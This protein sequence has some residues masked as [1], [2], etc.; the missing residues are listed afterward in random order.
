MTELSARY[1]RAESLLP[2]NLRKLVDAPRVT[3][4]W[5]RDTETFWYR[6]MTSAG[7]EFVLVDAEARTTRPA[8][9]HARLAVAL[10]G[11]LEQ[12]VEASALPFF[13]LD[14]R[15]GALRVTV[16]E[17]LVEVSLDSYLAEVVG[18]APGGETFSPDGRWAVGFDGEHDLALR[19]VATDEV[20]VLTGDGEEGYSYAQSPDAS[21][22]RVMQENLGFRTPPHV[23]WSQDS[24]RFVTFRL[25]QRDLELMH[26]VRS[27]PADGGRP[28][29]YSYRYAMVGDEHDGLAEFLVFD[30]A[31]G[32]A[33]AAGCG[34]L[35]NPY[36]SPIALGR[37]W[38]SDDGTTVRF[39]ASERGDRVARLYELD[40]ASGAT[41]VLVEERSESNVLYGPHFQDRNV[42]VLDSGEV[43]WWS[44]RS[45][46][47]HLYRVGADGAATALTSGEWLV[48]RL[49]AVDEESRRVV[50][51][52]AGRDPDADPY[53][54]ELCA[55]SLDG[56][57]VETLAAD[58]LDHETLPSRS[59][60]YFVDVMSAVDTPAVSVLRDL[61]GAVVLE[62]ER[63]DAS[64]LYASGWQAPE[65]V[66]VKAS[67]GV[68]DI[69]CAIYKPFDFDPAR[70]YPVLDEIY[71]GP[72]IS[73]A[74]IRF[75]L[76]GG[77]MVAERS[78]TIFAALGFAVVTVDGRGTAL[79]GKAFQ[80]DAR[81]GNDGGYIADHVAAI[82][83]LAETRP[84]LDLDRVGIYGHSGGGYA[85]TRALL[86]EP[87]FYKVAV[88]SAGDHD[89][90]TYHAWWGEKY[91][92]L[93]D[94][95]DYASHANVSRVENLKGKLL[96]AH[97]EMDDNVTPHL[98]LRLVN[99]LIEANK[100]FDLLI[101]PNAD[102]FM[103][104]NAAYWIRRR[105]D[106]FVRHLLGE[107][108]PEYR[109]ADIPF[110]PEVLASMGG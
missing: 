4:S 23:V 15:D 67:D 6:R 51:T 80:D 97:G 96:L 101:V 109:I 71:S 107:T 62:L 11:V 76:S 68:T 72:Q 53:V 58:G 24:T 92:G 52:A 102:H 66:K 7:T 63:A 70:R 31:S 8:F 9:D 99:A 1:A 57:E 87:D 36:L 14:L 61:G 91:Y 75:P 69:W 20:R 73:C 30:A 40:P 79:R 17:K 84:W 103:A 90:K 108:P 22:N 18:R 94:E 32:Q 16:E 89:D 65:R 100:D 110:D 2:H 81:R 21:A 34:P 26:L 60:R 78:G 77:V 85:S 38:W 59:G 37:V 42:E 29:P 95:F 49:V 41:R 47:G 12:E 106:Y 45:G 43:V 93:A 19:D 25:D 82:R 83:Q 48:R 98:T 3:P 54:Q 50:F 46:W 104:V 27:S 86:Q 28:R 55:V 10:N 13:A 105:W 64:A 5:I 88:S 35:P 44:E 74:P 39:L 33:T 56:G